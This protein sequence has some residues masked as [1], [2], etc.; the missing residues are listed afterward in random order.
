MLVSG[1]PR[2][3]SPSFRF[4]V[5]GLLC[6]RVVPLGMGLGEEDLEVGGHG[7]VG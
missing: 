6:H 4:F 3:P 2:R 7:L 1:G 5:P